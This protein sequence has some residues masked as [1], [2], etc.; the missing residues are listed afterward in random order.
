VVVSPDGRTIHASGFNDDR[1]VTLKRP[2][3]KPTLESLGPAS[4]PVTPG[5]ITLTV[6]GADFVPGATVRWN[7]AL[8]LATTFVHS[9]KLQAT[10]GVGLLAAAGTR[11]VTVVNPTPGGGESNAL[12]FTVTAPSDNPVPSIDELSPAGATA[13]GPGVTLTVKGANFMLDSRVRWNGVDRP[14]TFVSPTTLQVQVTAADVAQPG[15]AAV[16]VA[17]P[18]PGGG[19]S[20]AASFDVAAPGQ[21]PV[22]AITALSPAFVTAGANGALTLRVIGSNFV[23]GVSAEWNGEPRPT[24]LVGD[25]ELRVELSGADLVAAG[26]ASVRVVNP[27]PG[28]GG[29]NVVGFRIGAIGENPIPSV[30]AVSGFAANADGTIT[31]TVTGGGFVQ[32]AQARWND[33]DRAT[34][35]VSDTQLTL[36][37]SAADYGGGTAVITV[38]NPGPGG[39][40]SNEL[41]YT[42][43]RI[44]LPITIR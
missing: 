17:N 24:T 14:T 35:V 2:N 7:G 6:N 9:G 32:G 11:S 10:V 34:S 29:S 13:G 38:V 27:G 44:R 19:V 20:N 36:T 42:V 12:T 28:G 30:A 43:T 31:L 15:D 40:A 23:P 16:T 25:G 22:P 4:T 26:E 18:A 41:L 33:Q 39:G 1:L 5:A 37:I 8:N 3:P 21:N